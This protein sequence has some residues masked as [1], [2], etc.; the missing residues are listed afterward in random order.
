MQNELIGYVERMMRGI[1]ISDETL[2]LDVIAAV[3]PKGGVFL[4]EDHTAAHFRKELW[5][6]GI[7]DRHFWQGWLDSGAQ[8][9]MLRCVERKNELLA[10]HVVE[11][12]DAATDRE[13]ERI[14][15]SARANLKS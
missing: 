5:F 6:P 11:P 7:L 8:D 15:Q 10:R 4:G 13:V 1:E 14:L 12:L 2:A 9:T 3:V